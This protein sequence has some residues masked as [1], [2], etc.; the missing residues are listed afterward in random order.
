MKRTRRTRTTIEKR[1]TFVIRGLG[2]RNRVF[3]PECSEVVG[4]V[5]LDEAVKISGVSS[6]GVHRMIEDARIHFLETAVG[7]AFICPATL[8]ARVSEEGEMLSGRPRLVN[9]TM[10]T[11]E[12]T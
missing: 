4:L 11:E 2:K 10:K 8:L 5:T 6:R 1:E 9:R 3:C 12:E 7:I